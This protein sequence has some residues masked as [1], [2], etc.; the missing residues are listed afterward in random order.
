MSYVCT[1]TW[2]TEGDPVLKKEIEKKEKQMLK[3][4]LK[5]YDLLGY[6]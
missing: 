3:F 2:K 5:V 1:P 4:Y 6:M